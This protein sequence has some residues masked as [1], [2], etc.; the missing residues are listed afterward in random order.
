MKRFC[1]LIGAVFIIQAADAQ[2]SWQSALVRLSEDQQLTYIPDERGNTIPDFSKVGFASGER[3]IPK[4]EAMEFVIPA[5]GNNR[6]NIQRA[7]DR[8]AARPLGHDGF[9]GAVLLSKGTYEVNGS[10]VIEKSGI[11][12]RGEGTETIVRETATKQINL[13]IFKGD[14]DYAYPE[15]AGIKINE[16]LVPVGRRYIVLSDASSFKAGDSILLCRPGTA[17][18]IRDLRMDRIVERNGTRQWTPSYYDLY[19]ERIIMGIKGNKVFLDHPVVMEM[20]GK[21]GG[22]SVMKYQFRGRIRNCGIEDLTL[23]SAYVDET[24]ENHGWNAVFFSKVEQGWVQRV[25]SKYFGLGC[26]YIDHNSRNISVLNSQCLDPKSI[27]TGGRRYSFNCNGQLNLFKNCYARNGRHDYVTGSRVCGP[28]V[29]TQCAAQ[30]THSDIGPHHR[31]ASG[32]LYDQVVTDGAINVQDRG[33]WGSGHGWAGV[34]Q[35]IWNCSSPETAVQSPWVGGKNYC[36]G[37]TGSRHP[38]RFSDRPDGEWEGFNRAGLQPGSLYEA[39][40]RSRLSQ[41][42]PK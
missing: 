1:C 21:Y 15:S 28:N 24:D 34:T 13:F 36:I 6:E 41:A 2:P 27:I 19:Y 31:W 4:V 25:V 29:F 14:G 20:E 42:V 35:V 38:G 11:V 8:V 12:I 30:E 18:W 7:V 37:L 9:R 23:E 10:I 33:N 32:T 22:G 40:L 3:E 39:Q 5:G 26:V 16:D 17:N